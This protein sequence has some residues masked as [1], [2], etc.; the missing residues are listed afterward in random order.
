ME[1]PTW[2]HVARLPLPWKVVPAIRVEPTAFLFRG[3]DK[4]SQSRVRLSAH[5]GERP[6]IQKIAA[7]TSYAARLDPLE[8][9]IHLERSDTGS[10]RLA[11]IYQSRRQ[12]AAP[13]RTAS[14]LRGHEEKVAVPTIADI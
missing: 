7:P 13:G 5:E 8:N 6:M 12:G 14:E 2:R 11:S 10:R 9:A 4:K 3:K 1:W